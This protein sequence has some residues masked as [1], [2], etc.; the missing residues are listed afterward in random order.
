MFLDCYERQE[1]QSHI[2]NSKRQKQTGQVRC[3]QTA[4]LKRKPKIVQDIGHSEIAGT[5]KFRI[6]R[7][8][9]E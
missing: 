5:E 4:T 7:V 2:Y 8:K 1:K 9:R 3:Q 6:E